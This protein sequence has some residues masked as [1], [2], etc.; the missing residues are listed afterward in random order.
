MIFNKKR[1]KNPKR[2]ILQE[3]V[4]RIPMYTGVGGAGGK[5]S[6]CSMYRPQSSFAHPFTPSSSFDK[7][8]FK[9]KSSELET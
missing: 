8:T 2:K 7:P 5:R 1:K 3:E 6:S 4:I 9:R